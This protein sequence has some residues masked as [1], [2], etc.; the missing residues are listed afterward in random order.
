MD[1]VQD[2]LRLDVSQEF[3]GKNNSLYTLPE[4][5]SLHL[6]MDAWNTRFLL[7]WPIFRRHV[8]FR[9]FRYLKPKLWCPLSTI[10]LPALQ[11]VEEESVGNR[12][13]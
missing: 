10:K 8:S 2:A 5:N 4:T 11:R 6:K 9:E 7:G 1:F 12:F 3:Q 13:L